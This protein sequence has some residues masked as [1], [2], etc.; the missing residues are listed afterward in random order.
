MPVTVIAMRPYGFPTVV[1]ATHNGDYLCV[2]IS[3][4][5]KYGWSYDK[6]FVVKQD[7]QRKYE[8]S[9]T[10]EQE[11][12]LTKKFN[13]AKEKIEQITPVIFEEIGH[14]TYGRDVQK[15]LLESGLYKKVGGRRRKA[16]SRKTMKRKTSRYSRKH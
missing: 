14:E 2:D 13:E 6:L 10:D 4:P 5:E 3:R 8:G 16:M 12:N 1:V 9:L 11:T 7:A 15:F